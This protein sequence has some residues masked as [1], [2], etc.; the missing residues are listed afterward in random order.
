MYATMNKIL[1][2]LS[3]LLI[4]LIVIV[5][6]QNMFA[7]KQ[8]NEE[9]EQ[10]Q[11]GSVPTTV[12]PGNTVVLPGDVQQGNSEQGGEGGGVSTTSIRTISEEEFF[13]LKSKWETLNEEYGIVA[14]QT[15]M[16]ALEYQR[17]TDTFFITVSQDPIETYQPVAEQALRDALSLSEDGLCSL[18]VVI[19]ARTWK[20]Q[21][22]WWDLELL[23]CD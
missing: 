22:V 21:D 16:Y 7:Q 8:Q 11:T 12:F 1:I 4:V 18:P 5:V 6:V 13:T 20:T 17:D 3:A 9:F 15:D 10:T 23:G 14:T 19:S 2:F